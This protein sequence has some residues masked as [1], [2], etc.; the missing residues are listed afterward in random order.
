MLP[1]RIR[2]ATWN[3]FGSPFDALSLLMRR[4]FWPARLESAELARALGTYDV[5]CIQENLV[6]HVRERLE[7]LRRAAGFAHLWFDPLGPDLGSRTLFG[8]GLAMFSRWP[9]RARFE[10]LR[11]GTGPDLFARKGFTVADLELP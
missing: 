5:V 1:D 2:V 10:R 4:P 3:C 8:G 11:S 9:L 7:R 6:H